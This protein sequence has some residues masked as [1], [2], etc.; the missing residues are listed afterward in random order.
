MQN[1]KTIAI[2]GNCQAQMIEAIFALSSPGLIVKPL[3]PVFEIKEDAREQILSI[4]AE[5]DYDV[6]S[7]F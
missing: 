7:S 6:G 4:F 1:A 5:V 2:L 3:P